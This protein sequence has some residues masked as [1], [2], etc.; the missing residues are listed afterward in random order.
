M[1]RTQPETGPACELHPAAPAVATCTTCTARICV[2]C[3]LH[4]G[5]S[6]VCPR[7]AKQSRRRSRMARIGTRALLAVVVGGAYFA[8]AHAIHQRRDYPM[9]WGLDTPQ[10]RQL[11]DAHLQ[12][13]CD[14]GRL[15]RLASKLRDVGDLHGALE[16]ISLARVACG[17]LG[18]EVD[19]LSFEL[20]RRV[21][22]HR[23]AL[24]DL[25]RRIAR[26]P[27]NFARRMD[28]AHVDLAAGEP[29]AA[30]ADYMEALCTSHADKRLV[31]AEL[32]QVY[33]QLGR[34][35]VATVLGDAT[36]YTKLACDLDRLFDF[37]P[38]EAKAKMTDEL[39]RGLP[40]EL[41]ELKRPV[42]VGTLCDK[43][44]DPSP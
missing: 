13:P 31:L 19:A 33:E 42:F 34:H 17:T 5:L 10:V 24:A 15:M 20:H 35:G 8:T 22:D 25:D 43:G 3:T 4:D 23:G 21:H 26:D 28:R 39:R 32:R 27:Q 36:T 38:A 30:I 1:Y 11:V 7:C 16:H 44:S 14:A 9:L 2:P 12:Q 18:D 37:D 29:Q 6:T 40:P 41:D